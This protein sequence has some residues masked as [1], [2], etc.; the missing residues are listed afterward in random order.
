MHILCLLALRLADAAQRF[1]CHVRLTVIFRRTA[2]F[3]CYLACCTQDAVVDA[4]SNFLRPKSSFDLLRPQARVSLPSED[5][6]NSVMYRPQSPISSPRPSVQGCY[7]SFG[8]PLYTP[9]GPSFSFS[10]P[11]PL[12]SPFGNQ[13]GNTWGLFSNSFNGFRLN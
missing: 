5:E 9:S 10:E 12:A 1:P 11:A 7:S 3:A 8:F 2:T 6:L 4:P 13:W